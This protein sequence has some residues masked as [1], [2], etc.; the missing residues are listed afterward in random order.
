MKP[1]VLA[2]KPWSLLGVC[3][4]A[5]VTLLVFTLAVQLVC[6]TVPDFHGIGPHERGE[7]QAAPHSPSVHPISGDLSEQEPMVTFRF[8]FQERSIVCYH[9]EKPL[10]A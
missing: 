1:S 6:M 7:G 8:S 5:I 3:R 10:L 4:A 2:G 9:A